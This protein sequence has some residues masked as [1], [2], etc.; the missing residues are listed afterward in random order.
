MPHSITQEILTAMLREVERHGF[1]LMT[2]YPDDLRVHDRETLAIHAVPGATLAWCLGHSHTHLAPLGIHSRENDIPRYV[3]NLSAEDRFYQ[4]KVRDA[5]RFTLKEIG[6]SAFES[7]SI[8]PI[9]YKRSGVPE[10]FYL[11]HGRRR[12]G[13][14]SLERVA[15][16]RPAYRITI[17]PFCGISPLDRAALYQWAS[18]SAIEAA[19]TLWV[20][21]FINWAPAINSAVAA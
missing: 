12:V 15:N 5:A 17:T 18:N 2:R 1:K 11:E 13:F 8:T 6:R 19:H 16:G 9:P 20:T 3:T 10:S 4:I 21:W 7:L 14:I